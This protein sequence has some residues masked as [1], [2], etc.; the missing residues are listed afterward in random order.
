[1]RRPFGLANLRE[2]IVIGPMDAVQE[3][4]EPDD[5]FTALGIEVVSSAPPGTTEGECAQSVLAV[6]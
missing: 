6:A 5:L 1:M 4:R 3:A 2:L